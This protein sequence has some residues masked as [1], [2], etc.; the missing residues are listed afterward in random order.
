MDLPLIANWCQS[1]FILVLAKSLS[2]QKYI[3]G[4]VCLKALVKVA[5]S[6]QRL[7]S[8]WQVRISNH[9]MIVL[10]QLAPKK[11]LP[12]VRWI[13]SCRGSKRVWGHA[14]KSICWWNRSTRLV[15]YLFFWFRF[16]LLFTG[17]RFVNR[18]KISSS[19]IRSVSP[20][21]KMSVS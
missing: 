9:T 3:L 10:S 11:P 15:F 1:G 4:K 8:A 21:L 7:A 17:C 19:W 12:W 14:S 20:F 18:A 6:L 2:I 5:L 16:L 13:N